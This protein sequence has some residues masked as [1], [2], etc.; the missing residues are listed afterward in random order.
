MNPHQRR[1]YL[2]M[3]IAVVVAMI[4]AVAAGVFG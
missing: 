4:A 3:W 1:N 2:L